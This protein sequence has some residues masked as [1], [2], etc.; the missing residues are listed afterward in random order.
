MSRVPGRYLSFP[1]AL[2]QAA[3]SPPTK[4]TTMLNTVDADTRDDR[5]VSAL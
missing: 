4:A 1:A 3:K 2:F 5:G